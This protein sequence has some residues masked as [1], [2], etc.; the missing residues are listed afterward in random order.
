MSMELSIDNNKVT[1]YDLLFALKYR[2]TTGPIVRIDA[3]YTSSQQVIDESLLLLVNG[4]CLGN[5]AQGTDGPEQE[6]HSN[7]QE[8]DSHKECVQEV[9]TPY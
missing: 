4:L 5:Q 1:T 2:S 9:R 7:D 6:F 8:H 3:R